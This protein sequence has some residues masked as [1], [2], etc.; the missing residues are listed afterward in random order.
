VNVKKF[1]LQLLTANYILLQT[2]TQLNEIIYDSNLTA[3]TIG[4]FSYHNSAQTATQPVRVKLIHVKSDS[5]QHVPND[6]MSDNLQC[7]HASQNVL[8]SFDRWKSN[9]N[10]SYIYLYI[11]SHVYI[12]FCIYHIVLWQCYAMVK[13]KRRKETKFTFLLNNHLSLIMTQLYMK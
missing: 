13:V 1:D 2:D 5:V 3:C 4:I 11:T 10:I 9:I 7:S 6:L 12:I 8:S